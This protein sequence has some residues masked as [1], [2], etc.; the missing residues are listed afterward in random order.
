MTTKI[1]IVSAYYKNE[2]MTVDFLN[3]LTGTLP[4]DTEVILVNAGSK[5]IEHPI[6][7]KRIDLPENKSF[8]NSMNAGIIEATGDYICV[9]GNDVFPEIGWIRKLLKIAI[10]QDADIT[11]P[12][13]D[14]TDMKNYILTKLENGIYEARFFPAVCWLISRCCINRVGLFDEAYLIGMYEDNDYIER[15]RLQ[16][17]KLIV[18]DKV[19]VKHLESQT[20][21]LLG[22]IREI[23]NNNSKLFHSRYDNNVI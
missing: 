10:E 18:T 23:M 15:L 7:T 13:N 19:V 17:G 2:E 14:K 22:D 5:K 20:L 9:V 16:K 4:S 1:S 3:N 8:A 21:K 11:S 6:I 12:I